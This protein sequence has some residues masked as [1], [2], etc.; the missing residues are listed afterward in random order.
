VLS[1]SHFLLLVVA[2]IA[3]GLGGSV[4]GMASVFS[5]PA[6]L[7]I[8]INP[9]DANVT[10]SVGIIFV[11]L[12]ST[13]GSRQEWRHQIHWIKKLAPANFV[14]GVIGA[15]LLL[16]TPSH[17]FQIL[18][19]ILLG[20]ASIVILLPKPH[21][22]AGQARISLPYLRL[23]IGIIGIYCGYFGAASGAM[24][25]AVLIQSIGLALVDANS[26]KNVLLG[27]S[28]TTAAILFI[29]LGHV[30]WWAVAPLA[31]GFFIGGR[32]GPIIVRK[33]PQ[34]KLKYAIAALGG[35]V[36]LYLAFKAFK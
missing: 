9:I 8:G 14:G 3:A 19:P 17:T 10:N 28:N 30:H 11:S 20:I 2:G 5:Y 4:V 16:V 35:A 31:I 21:V 22:P 24:T 7:L 23:L 1:A 33:L 34:Q 13:I 12:G 15:L 27:V 18:V 36:S 6:L 26:I 25:L 29:G 32:T